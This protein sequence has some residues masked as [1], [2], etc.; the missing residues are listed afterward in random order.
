MTELGSC[1]AGEAGNTNDPVSVESP[2]GTI[3]HVVMESD[4]I[5]RVVLESSAPGALD[6]TN[7][8]VSLELPLGSISHVVI[9]SDLISRPAAFVEFETRNL[10]SPPADSLGEPTVIWIVD[11]PPPFGRMPSPLTSEEGHLA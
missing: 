2:P 5:R 4:L 6:K 9:E 11:A 10:G 1:G 3:S 7:D 8:P